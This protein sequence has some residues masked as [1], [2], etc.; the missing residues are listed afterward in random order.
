M[1]EIK[2]DDILIFDNLNDK[3]QYIIDNTKNIKLIDLGLYDE[4][5]NLEKDEIIEKIK[6]KFSIVNLNE[7][8]EKFLLEKLDCKDDIE[9]Y[10]MFSSQLIIIT[11]GIKGNDFI[12]ENNKYSFPLSKI[13]NEVDDSGAGDAF[14]SIIIKN[15]INNNMKISSDKLSIW[16]KETVPLVSKILRRIGSRT[17][18]KKMY[19]L[20]K[21]DICQL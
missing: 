15:W 11:R 1:K 9:L 13:I 14:F 5:I 4:F 3:N 16:V 10:K 8:V 17:Y 19:K 18:I 21:K 6:N 7:R 12:Y 2:K 20:K